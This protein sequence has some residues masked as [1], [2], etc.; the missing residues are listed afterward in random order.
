MQALRVEAAVGVSDVRP[1]QTDDPGIPLEMALGELG[2]LAV[3]VRGQI[4]A[5][6]AQLLVHD[7]EVVDEPLSGR[8]DRA[9]VLDGACQCAV[10]GKQDAPILTDAGPKGVSAA[11]IVGGRLCGGE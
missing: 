7:V 11:R 10:G 9:L 4:I 8:R 5:D 2:Q 1:G 3:V 6:L